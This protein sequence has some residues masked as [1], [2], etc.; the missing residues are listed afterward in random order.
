[1]R[2]KAYTQKGWNQEKFYIEDE[3]ERDLVVHA[4]SAEEAESHFIKYIY[5]NSLYSK[6]ETK[7]WLEDNPLYL[8]EC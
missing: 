8:V 3:N 5:N 2:F 7:K 6:E 1:M 4:D